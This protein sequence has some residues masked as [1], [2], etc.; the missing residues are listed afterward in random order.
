MVAMPEKV[1]ENIKAMKVVVVATVDDKGVSNAVPVG[2][3]VIKDP[4]TIL[5]GDN[6]FKKTAENAKKPNF[7]V[8]V[9]S[10]VG[11][12]GY[13]VKGQGTYVTEG[14]DYETIKQAI[15]SMNPNLPAKGCIVMKV[16][17]VFDVAPG[18]NAGNKIV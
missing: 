6:F 5:I 13:Q 7:N 8:G 17:D 9:T 18:P 15:K 2:S 14:P 3:I 16:T 10:W 12:E 4:E 11:M 1:M